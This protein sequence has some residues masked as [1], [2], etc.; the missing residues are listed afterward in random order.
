M[1]WLDSIEI[2]RDLQI[3]PDCNREYEVLEQFLGKTQDK[4]TDWI[5]AV[6][7]DAYYIQ[8]RCPQCLEMRYLCIQALTPTQFHIEKEKDTKK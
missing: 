3:C 2:G 7:N 8:L 1:G 6:F 4:L 5:D